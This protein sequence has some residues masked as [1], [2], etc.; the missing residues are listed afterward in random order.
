MMPTVMAQHE[1]G[2]GRAQHAQGIEHDDRTVP[3]DRRKVGRLHPGVKPVTGAAVQTCSAR[4]IGP[5]AKMAFRPY[6]APMITLRRYQPADLE[7]LYAI[8][9]AT[10]EA[11]SDASHLYADKRLIG[12]IYSA[13]Y[14]VLKPD[15]ALV[16]EDDQGIAGYALGV[17]DT[18]SWEDHLEQAW[19]P[20][21][22]LRYPDPGPTPQEG[23]SADQRRQF[24]IHHP[25]RTPQ[26]IVAAFPAH[27]HL[28]LLP[29]S[30]GR[31]HG[32]AL[33][34]AWLTEAGSDGVD[35]IHVGVNRGNSRAVRFWRK[36][37]FADITPPE[38]VDSR[39]IWMGRRQDS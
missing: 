17:P 25:G 34:D 32:P 22:R 4:D 14:A 35:A 8:S 2:I 36:A 27:L 37:G 3:G 16:A 15:L 12:L 39:T 5:M 6:D 38:S 13:P 10:G 21:L 1:P 19:W 30:Q 31:G 11:G 28:N 33:L 20:A 26:E 7:S 29:R 23:W 18:R 24:M 9:L